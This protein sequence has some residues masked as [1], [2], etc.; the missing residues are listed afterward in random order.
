[1]SNTVPNRKCSFSFHPLTIGVIMNKKFASLA[2]GL[3][4][5]LSFTSCAGSKPAQNPAGAENPAQQYSNPKQVS[6][7]CVEFDTDE[8]ITGFGQYR[9]SSALLGKL[10]FE[11]TEIAKDNARQKLAARFQ[12]ITKKY[13]ASWS[14]NQGSD[15]ESKVVSGGK[16]I[17]DRVLNDARNACTSQDEMPGPDGHQSVYIGIRIYHKELASRIAE[18]IE[19]KLTQEEKMRIDFNAKKFADEVESEF[20]KFKEENKPQ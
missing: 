19:D 3:V 6:I 12:G 2:A 16:E 1:M 9:G 14:N 5:A 13:T 17:I 20:G 11:A 7:P 4:L 18:G 10:V 15:L 8:Y